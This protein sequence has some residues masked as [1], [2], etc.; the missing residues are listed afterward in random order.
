MV[1]DLLNKTDRLFDMLR[2]VAFNILAEIPSAPVDL[3]ESRERIR[4][5]T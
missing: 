1:I 3:V 5:R 4:S 2:E